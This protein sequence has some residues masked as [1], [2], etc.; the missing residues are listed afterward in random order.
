MSAVAAPA[1]EAHRAQLL[2]E[3]ELASLLAVA[4]S[5]PAAA[6]TQLRATLESIVSEKRCDWAFAEAAAPLLAALE[7]SLR[8]GPVPAP[9][10][11]E[12]RVLFG[13]VHARR[14]LVG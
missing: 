3:E 11:S 8:A 14:V 13:A 12:R 6:R 9:A 1:S 4:P 5:L 2:C 10:R 7:L